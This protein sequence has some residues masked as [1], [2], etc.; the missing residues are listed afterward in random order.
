MSIKEEFINTLRPAKRSFNDPKWVPKPGDG[1]VDCAA[2]L[3]TYGIII[4]VVSE[5]KALVMWSKEL[6]LHERNERE[7]VDSMRLQ[8]QDEE[9]NQIMRILAEMNE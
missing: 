4:S 6:T 1:I 7:I 5:I 9:D 3:E 8:I 2:P